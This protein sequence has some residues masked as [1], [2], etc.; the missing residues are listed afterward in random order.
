MQNQHQKLDFVTVYLI[1]TKREDILDGKKWELSNL[2]LKQNYKAAVV[3]PRS[4]T[5]V[6]CAVAM[7][8]DISCSFDLKIVTHPDFLHKMYSINKAH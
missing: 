8:E 7:F 3:M 1:N 5:A 6:R 2:D 4:S